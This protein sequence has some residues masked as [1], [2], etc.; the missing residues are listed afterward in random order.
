MP[1]KKDGLVKTR[2]VVL[3][4][5]V[6]A[7]GGLPRLAPSRG[8]TLLVTNHGIDHLV[9]YDEQG[10]LV[11]LMPNESRCVLLRNPTK[12]QT[13][14]YAVEGQSYATPWFDPTTLDGW[15]LEV[16][17]TPNL[18]GLTLRPL[19]EPCRPGGAQLAP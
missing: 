19:E 3:L 14:R 12:T 18:D 8:P 16:G 17:T 7:C 4:A 6:A 15:R 9:V 1:G 5:A 10:R 2:W 13:L 11:T